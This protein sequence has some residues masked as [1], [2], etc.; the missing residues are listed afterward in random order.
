MKK[1]ASSS[2]VAF[3]WAKQSKKWKRLPKGW[4]DE[5][6]KKFWTTI[7]KD[8]PKH[9]VWNCI[10][11]MTGKIG[12]PGAFCGGLADEMDP[13]WRQRVTK[14]PAEDRAKARSYWKK[15]I[16]SKGGG[17]E[18]KKKASSDTIPVRRI[19]GKGKK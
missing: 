15:K 9:K 13:G 3:A 10:Y 11:K 16:E 7:G 4:T 5:S 14:E 6:V 17:G 12:D 19:Y 1:T 18:R 2:R 8:A